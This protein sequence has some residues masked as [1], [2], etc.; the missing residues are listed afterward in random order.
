MQ[1]AI[2][3]PRGMNSLRRLKKSKE[4][5]VDGSRR[6]VLG[7]QDGAPKSIC[8]KVALIKVPEEHTYLKNLVLFFA[9]FV[10]EGVKC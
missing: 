6:S 8:Y 1:G 4:K 5:N 7:F 10:F 3:N 9:T 2:K